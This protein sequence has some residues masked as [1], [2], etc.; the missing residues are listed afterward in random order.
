MPP[1]SSWGSL[2]SAAVLAVQPCWGS[3]R[4][5][6]ASVSIASWVLPGARHFCRMLEAPGRTEVAVVP[7]ARSHAEGWAP[8]WAVPC[9][10]SRWRV[11]PVDGGA[12]PAGL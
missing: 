10:A 7:G 4:K 6:H 12:G 11:R 2:G 1:C 9:V 5:F 3:T 8:L